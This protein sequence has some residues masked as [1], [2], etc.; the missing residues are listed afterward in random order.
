VTGIIWWTTGLSLL[1]GFVLSVI[2]TGYIR[3]VALRRNFVDR[4][5]GHKSHTQPVALGGGIAITFALVAPVIAGFVVLYLFF[6][7]KSPPGWLPVS[8]AEHIPGL[9]SKSTTA[10][11]IAAGAL[12]L[13][14]IGII[15]DKKHLGPWIKFGVQFLVA[16]FIAYFL[17]VRIMTFLGLGF[18]VV[19]TICWIVTITNA[20]NFLDNMDGLSAGVGAITALIFALS[21]L[22]VGQ[23][24][25]PT[26]ACLFVGVM[27]GFLCYNYP[28]AKIFMGD[29]GSLVIGYFMAVVTILT[30]YWNPELN[31]KP[32][33]L[34][35][36]VVLAV[37]LYDAASVVIIR[38]KMGLSPFRG[39][40]RHFSHRLLQRGMSSKSAVLTIYL[41]TAATGLGAAFLPRVPWDI[42]SLIIMQTL[43]VVLIIAVLEQVKT[44]DE[45]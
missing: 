11:G 35:P 15:D 34:V 43:L 5:G 37:P 22:Q 10:L 40:Q 41:A 44:N 12:L 13:H 27:F 7:P 8:I 42:A 39:D 18:S 30:T 28:P 26:L 21:A 16:V 45:A 25:V 2:G 17:D 14:A 9:M 33:L 4:P 1:T 24:F 32:G 3:R 38:L 19:V 29:A 36:L 31:N 23:I 6:D 20:F